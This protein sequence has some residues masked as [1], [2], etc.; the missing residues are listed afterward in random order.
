[1]LQARWALEKGDYKRKHKIKSQK[2]YGFNDSLIRR[3]VERD[4]I[5]L[6]MAFIQKGAGSGED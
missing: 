2:S 3:G 4:Y 6:L 1:V 5:L